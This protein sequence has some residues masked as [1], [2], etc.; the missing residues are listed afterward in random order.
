MKD[1]YTF[2]CSSNETF[3]AGKFE[4]RPANLPTK[5]D[6]TGFGLE[7]IPSCDVVAFTECETRC[8]RVTTA[9]LVGVVMSLTE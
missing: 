3:P 6:A 1:E 4:F 9:E 8:M 2:L 7:I 5:A